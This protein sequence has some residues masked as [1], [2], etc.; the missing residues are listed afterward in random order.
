MLFRRLFFLISFSCFVFLQPEAQTVDFTAPS[1]ICTGTSFNIINNTIGASTYKWNFCSKDLNQAPA[2]QNLGGFGMLD[3]PTYMDIVFT[4]NNYYGFITNF[5]SGDLV[6]LDFGNSLMNNPTAVNLGNINGVI[7]AG[8]NGGIQVVQ[9]EGKWYAIIVAGYPPGGINPRII[10][11]AFGTSITNPDPTGTN[12]GNQGNMYDPNDLILVQEGTEWIGITVNGEYNSIT[13]FNFGSSLDNSPTGTNLGNI[14]NLGE[15][16]GLYLTHNQGNIIVF[17]TNSGDKTRIGGMFNI[18]RLNFGSSLNN[19][20]TAVNI[21][22]V[23]N[24]L[25]HP[26]DIVLES[27]CNET[28]GYVL[29]A[30]PFY[31]SLLKLN[32]NN[33]ITN[34]IPA[35]TELSHLSFDYPHSVTKFHKKGND[36]VAFVVNRGNSTI[37]RIIFAY[38]NNASPPNSTQQIP[39]AISYNR[40]G[41][42][43]IQL[44]VNE[45]TASEKSLCKQVVVTSCVDTL[46]ITNDT[47]ICGGAPLQILTHPA[48]SYQWSPS[49]FL[50]DPTAATPLTT[51]TQNIKY[52]VDALLMGDNLVKNADF[53]NGNND[54]ASG[55][56]YT[57][58]NVIEGEYFV[59]ND[60]K[61]WNISL[62]Y[63]SDHTSGNG[64][65]LLVNG[66]PAAGVEVWS[67]TVNIKSNTDYGFS[68]WLQALWAPNPANLQFYINGTPLAGRITAGVPPCN[69]SQFSGVW[70]SGG[71]TSVTLSIVNTNTSVIGN[72]FAIDDIS[73]AE[74]IPVRDSISINVKQP[75]IK[76]NNDTTICAGAPV[77]LYVEQGAFFT[78]SPSTGLSNNSIPNPIATPATTTEYVVIGVDP[79]GCLARDSVL[80]TVKP[81]P[82]VNVTEDTTICRGKTI[83]LSASGGGTYE[84]SPATSLSNTS[85]PN[86]VSSASS[87]INYIVKV[88]AAN[89]CSTTDTVKIGVSAYPQFAASATPS[90]CLGNN[91]T[92]TASGGDNYLWSPATSLPD[93]TLPEITFAPL[94]SGT[95]AVNIIDNICHHDTTINVVVKVNP[96]PVLSLMKS[97]DINC[98][99]PTALLQAG[100]ARTYSW[101]PAE[102]LSSASVAN[103]VA[104]PDTTTMYTVTGINEFGCSSTASTVVN[105]DKS[106]V[107]RFVVPNAFTPNNDGK[108]DCFGIQRWGNAEIKQF[109]IYNRWGKII[110]QTADPS[111]CW[112]GTWKG[113]RQEGGGYIYI[114]RA[115]TLCGEVTRKGLLT[116]I[117]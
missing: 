62:D 113:Q 82:I 78:W 5:S 33:D 61:T 64:Q 95:Y 112:D 67:Q 107:P 1:S 105:V 10:K 86:P 71:N 70:N 35:S 41:I 109:S 103:P 74:L 31:N 32:F 116:L 76:A 43:N 110:F 6:R 28:L 99:E 8:G 56:T 19:N 46:I 51:T 77:Q 69:W 106:G 22:N 75:F 18:T 91:A 85:I 117:R 34:S 115:N 101:L 97:N 54:F 30:H 26:R 93:P 58:T 12:W 111:Q 36:L 81:S 98:N 66:S 55:Y 17:V 60:P 39:P 14:G 96:L 27:F 13:R 65:M 25:Q 94:S 114:I 11:I 7:P 47:T 16:A 37:T 87:D 9:N 20:P 15:P 89:A 100:G 79:A 59:G 2:T 73:F 57:P 108:N 72:D 38:C 88:T 48:I 40:A 24:Q 80:I 44:T 4:N 49:S 63:C 29:N 50:D 23:G 21:G 53:S 68:A 45:G 52:Y 92:L 3:E 104:T 90:V 83:Q 102:Y 84:W 42:Y